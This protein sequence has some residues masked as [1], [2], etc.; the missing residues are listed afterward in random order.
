MI[1]TIAQA[2]FDRL[3]DA[4]PPD[5]TYGRSDIR[6]DPM[7]EALA[8]YLEQVLHM[9]LRDAL[10]E[11][12]LQDSWVDLQA[13][14]VQEAHTRFMEV[15][16]RHQAFPAFV[17]PDFLKN[18][19]QQ[20]LYLVIQPTASLIDSVFD[21]L[22]TPVRAGT[23][24]DRMGLYPAKI[25]YREALET[26]L[27]E[28]GDEPVGR[29]RFEEFLY[30]ADRQLVSD[31]SPEDWFRLF[32]PLVNVLATA[33]YGEVPAEFVKAFLQ[34]KGAEKVLH[35]LEQ[36]FGSEESIPFD[37]LEVLFAPHAAKSDKSV[38]KAANAPARP[39]ERRQ[40]AQPL[41]KR[42]AQSGDD[43]SSTGESPASSSP[44]DSVDTS[45]EPRWKQF[46]TG[47]PT[48]A[49]EEVLENAAA[50]ERTPAEN[51]APAEIETAT[52]PEP[53]VPIFTLEQS[54]SVLPENESVV[55]DTSADAGEAPTALT[56]LEHTV[57]GERGAR[58]RD[59]FVRC[60]FQGKEQAYEAVL[61]RLE[62]ARDWS[63]ASQTIANEV[64]LKHHVNIYSPP[65]VTFTEAVEARYCT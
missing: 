2:L 41:W 9:K 52:Q 29:D 26:W 49:T 17:W 22:G 57:L 53:S 47:S 60:L 34:E 30:Q 44:V 3:I 48:A 65:A 10:P 55:S 39:A 13:A 7:P 8:D 14:E 32:D 25:P 37:K 36:Q 18:A 33:G 64:F 58:N 23:M 12:N 56:R 45:A 51:G 46:R 35:R 19:C 40:E 21:P 54:H 15:M 42:F 1:T 5:H 4:F 50:T 43:V 11:S 61:E 59:L 63:E 38:R 28:Q 62:D 27:D 24:R 31:S 6:R 20:T 16:K